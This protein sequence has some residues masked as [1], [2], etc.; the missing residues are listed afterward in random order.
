VGRA[1]DLLA[2]GA[3]GT[4]LTLVTV[5]VVAGVFGAAED[6]TGE[7]DA[8]AVDVTVTGCAPQ[9]ASPMP[10]PSTPSQRTTACAFM[11][12][13]PNSRQSLLAHI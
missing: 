2:G 7:V 9:A 8:G 4:V 11:A 5:F 10:A 13:P 12:N 3:G 6:D 1:A